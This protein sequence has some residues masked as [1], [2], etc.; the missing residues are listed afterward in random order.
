VWRNVERGE[1]RRT[2][3]VGDTLFAVAAE[4]TRMVPLGDG[5]FRVGPY[6]EVRFD[7]PEAPSRMIVRTTAEEVTYVRADTAVLTPAQLAEYAG[8]YRSEEVEATHSWKV[9]KGQLVVYANNRRLGALEPSYKD[10]F[11][12]GDNVIDVQRDAK[13]RITGFT[14]EAGRVR[15]LRFSRVR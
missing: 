12:R 9:E 3:L 4:R 14:V 5:R 1:V 8:E 2:R 6:S 7:N 15:H 11:T 10:G 13:G